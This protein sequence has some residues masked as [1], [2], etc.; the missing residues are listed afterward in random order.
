M[1]SRSMS[2]DLTI[3]RPAALDRTDFKQPGVGMPDKLSK[4]HFCYLAF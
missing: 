1:S 3:A 4:R 2:S